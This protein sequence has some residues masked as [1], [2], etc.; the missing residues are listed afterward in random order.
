MNA[1]SRSILVAAWALWAAV[2]GASR[3]LA[4]PAVSAVSAWVAAPAPGA[5]S[6]SAYVQVNNP[7][8]Y[9]VYITGATAD[10]ASK[11][12]LR[13][14]AS[15]GGES[16]VVAEFA[17]PAYGA[18]DAAATAPHLRLLELTRTLAAGDT[19]QL[20]LTTDGGVQLKVAAPVRAQ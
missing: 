9:D 18:T 6:A 14:G 20:T 12:E 19:V 16:R 10:V 17:V 5:T 4:Q 13:S 1:R 2:P 3:V 7:T 11:V 8:M 15:G